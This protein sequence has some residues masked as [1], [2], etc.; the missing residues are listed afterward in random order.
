[1]TAVK[2]SREPNNAEAELFGDEL[3]AC[4]CR[5]FPRAVHDRKRSEERRRGVQS[6]RQVD[7]WPIGVS[8]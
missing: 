6:E 8:D 2:R 5:V 3:V 1:M 7:P 4:S